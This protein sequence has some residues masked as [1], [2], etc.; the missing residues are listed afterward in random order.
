MKSFVPARRD[1]SFAL[2]GSRLAGT[3]LFT[4]NRP[5]PPKRDVKVI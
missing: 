1:P 5:S 4:C 3:K 2:P